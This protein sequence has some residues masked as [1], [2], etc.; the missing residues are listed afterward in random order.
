MTIAFNGLMLSG[1]WSGVGTY[2]YNLLKA[3]WTI[4]QTNTYIGWIPD[5]S[6]LDNFAHQANVTLHATP[7]STQHMA[8]HFLWEQTRLPFALRRYQTDVFFSPSYTLP[9]LRLSSS[10]HVVTV[11]DLVF[12]HYP[13]TKSRLFRLYMQMTMRQIVRSANL[14]IADSD[15]TKRDL[16]DI[17]HLSEDRLV[18]IHLAASDYFAQPVLADTLHNV[19]KRYD[20]GDT[21]I[22]AVGDLEPRKNVATLIEAVRMLKQRGMNDLQ[23]VL[24][25]KHR[26]GMERL[27][28]QIAHQNLTKETIITGYITQEDLSALYRLARVFVYPSLYEGFGIPPLEAML[29]GTPVVASNASSVP[30]VIGNAGILVDPTDPQ[31]MADGIEQVLSDDVTAEELIRLGHQ[32]A[33]QFSWETTAR[34]TLQAFQTAV[35]D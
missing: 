34:R 8:R 11:H 16:I 31:H 5:T 19:Q 26:R 33:R 9:L 32:Q 20:L 14:I 13:E 23:L 22:L 15:Q 12:L 30:E 18:T 6:S 29:A 7:V 21:V 1:Q 24:V 27:Y 2:A 17:Y 35:S 10:A 28:K 25:G 4:D 3:L